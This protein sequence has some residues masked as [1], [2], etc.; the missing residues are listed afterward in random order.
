MEQFPKESDLL[1]KVIY[2]H[3]SSKITSAAASAQKNHVDAEIMIG[4]T[5]YVS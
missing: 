1:I 3:N 4:N 5:W 2:S